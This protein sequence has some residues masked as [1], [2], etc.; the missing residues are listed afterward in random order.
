MFSSL[1]CVR[2]VRN[3]NVS[4]TESSAHKHRETQLLNSMGGS[5]FQPADNTL[6][7]VCPP[8]LS[9]PEGC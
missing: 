1:S 6:P 9:F 3:M 5:Q 7:W 8:H 2:K 4:F